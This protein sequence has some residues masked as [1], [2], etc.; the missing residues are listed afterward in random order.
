MIRF[1]RGYVDAGVD[2]YEAQYQ[3]QALRAVKRRAAQLGYEL[4]PISDDPCQVDGTAM[5]AE[6]TLP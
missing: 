2:Y 3:R 1:G 5:A 4:I 6:A